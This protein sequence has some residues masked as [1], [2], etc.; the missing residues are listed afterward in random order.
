MFT[1]AARGVG[2]LRYGFL[3]SACGL[4]LIWLSNLVLF[5]FVS[6]N[7]LLDFVLLELWFVVCLRFEFG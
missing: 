7:W 3:V 1:F 4:D 5:D 6:V 2:F